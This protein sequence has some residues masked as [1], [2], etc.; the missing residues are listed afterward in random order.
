MLGG[1]SRLEQSVLRP[2]ADA[3]VAAREALLAAAPGPTERAPV[4]TGVT[5]PAVPAAAA[6]LAAPTTDTIGPLERLARLHVDGSLTD[7]EFVAAKRKIL[8]L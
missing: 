3:I 5:L 6:S 8:D 4:Q 1:A 7:E 2:F